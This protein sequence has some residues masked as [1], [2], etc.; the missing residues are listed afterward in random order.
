M[1]GIIGK[2]GVNNVVPDLIKGLK[3]LEYRGYD[4]AGIGVINNNKISRIRS[5]GRIKTLEKETENKFFSSFVGIGHTRWATHGSPTTENAHPHISPEGKFALVHNG[6]IENS[7][8][9]KKRV[10]PEE[11]NFLSETDTEVA[12][13]LLEKNYKGDVIKAVSLTCEELKGSYAFGILCEDFPDRI[14]ATAKNSPLIVAKGDDGFYIASDIIGINEKPE[15]FYRL[16]DGEICSVQRENAVFFNECGEKISKT[17]EKT[18]VEN[19]E[20]TK[21]EYEHFMLKEIM[22]QPE[23][24]GKTIE[25]FVTKNKI[26]FSDVHIEDS[27]FK[28]KMSKI[29][30]V[31]CGSAYHT[32]LSVKYLFE[33]LC[34]LPC[35]VTL[36]S[37]FRYSKPFVNENTLA[38]FISQSGETAD[39]L[40]ALHLAKNCGAR[41]VSI[42]NVKG[43]AIAEESENVIYTKAGR[44]IAVATTKAYSAQLVALYGLSV[45]VSKK[46]GTI[47]AAQEKFYIEEMRKLP[48][49]ITE[50]LEKVNETVKHIAKEIYLTESVFYIGRLMDYAIAAEGS[51]KLKEISYINSQVLPAGE[52]K[53]GTISLINKGTPIIAILGQTEIFD[54]TSSNMAEV[55]ARGARVIAVTD[56]NMK[57]RITDGYDLVAVS[58]TVKEFKSSLLVLPLQLLGYYTAKLRG[59]DIDKPK[60]LAKSVTVE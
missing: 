57:N 49:K 43:S 10:L 60:N 18:Q 7:E 59:C 52:L 51:L 15:E 55:A 53:H 19:N 38:L 46:C 30:I 29:S 45:F 22:E 24:V 32:G 41:C 9:L 58:D 14:F 23:S 33:D 40:A 13:H 28:N 34:K 27:F 8:E 48:R 6:I 12:V 17:P 47:T 39:T 42:V 3:H 20:I 31:A 54:K 36:A 37:E 5:V 50:T 35:E 44:E 16:K 4:S 11:T 26:E 2:V 1:C 56:E 21:G 25:S